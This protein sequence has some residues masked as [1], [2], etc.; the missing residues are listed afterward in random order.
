M[1]PKIIVP[2]GTHTRLA[3]L[4]FEKHNTFFFRNLASVLKLL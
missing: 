2:A 1:S 4:H 3:A